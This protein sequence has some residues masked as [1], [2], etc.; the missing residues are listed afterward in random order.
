MVYHKITLGWILRNISNLYMLR[1]LLV[2]VEQV[3]SNVEKLRNS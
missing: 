2:M 3:R 1:T